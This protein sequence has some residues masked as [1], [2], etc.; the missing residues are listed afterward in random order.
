MNARDF[1]KL[2]QCC[3]WALTSFSL[4]ACASGTKQSRAVNSA[5][6]IVIRS[7]EQ[8]EWNYYAQP[9]QYQARFN[10]CTCDPALFVEVSLYGSWRHVFLLGDDRVIQS[11]R[12]EVARYPDGHIFTLTCRQ[13]DSLYVSQHGQF[14]YSLEAIRID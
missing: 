12:N 2:I 6:D 14:F 3:L 4:I 5:S 9:V 13:N 8:T 11:I 7:L 10:P 1:L